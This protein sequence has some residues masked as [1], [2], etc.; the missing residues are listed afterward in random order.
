MN[1]EPVQVDVNML[2]QIIGELFVENYARKRG[3][4]NVDQGVQ[5]SGGGIRESQPAPPTN[6][7]V[8]YESMSAEV[9][10]Q[11]IKR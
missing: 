4:M 5:A 10:R 6:N 8:P 2:L 11:N 7:S 9:S 1:P 3:M